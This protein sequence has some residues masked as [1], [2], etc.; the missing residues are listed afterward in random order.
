[1]PSISFAPRSSPCQAR[2]FLI[3]TAVNNAVQVD[4]H[5]G[6]AVESDLVPLDVGNAISLQN[7]VLPTGT[8]KIT[9]G[10]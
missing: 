8:S 10:A 4:P 9:G 7:L 6:I 3:L 2:Q 1:M 5:D